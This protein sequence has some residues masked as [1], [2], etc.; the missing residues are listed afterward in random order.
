MVYKKKESANVRHHCIKRMEEALIPRAVQPH[1]SYIKDT[2]WNA[3]KVR[4]R[5]VVFIIVLIVLIGVIIILSLPRGEKNTIIPAATQIIMISKS[6]TEKTTTI[7]APT[8]RKIK[9]T[10]VKSTTDK[11]TTKKSTTV[12]STTDASGVTAKV[13]KP[14]FGCRKNWIRRNERCYFF[15]KQTISYDDITFFCINLLST[16]VILDTPSDVEWMKNVVNY[17]TWTMINNHDDDGW[18]SGYTKINLFIFDGRYFWV[19]GLSRTQIHRFNLGE[20]AVIEPKIGLTVV[21]ANQERAKA[22]CSTTVCPVNW[23][24]INKICYSEPNA[25]VT[26]DEALRR[27]NLL[28]ATLGLLNPHDLYRFSRYVY[29]WLGA[30]YENGIWT[31]MDGS[32]PEPWKIEVTEQQRRYHKK[33]CLVYELSQ[34]VFLMP[35]D[36]SYRFMCGVSIY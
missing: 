13:M 31:T 16:G 27:C 6:T 33:M 1:L 3:K 15:T 7:N 8:R 11:S 24:L 12:T 10:T 18:Y 25:E 34:G 30:C 36:R 19:D 17:T 4:P 21:N 22:A 23:Y 9:S 32:S 20:N 26:Y 29:I 5:I 28:N 14:I 35:H 2:F